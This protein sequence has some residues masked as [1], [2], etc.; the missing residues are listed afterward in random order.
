M[1]GYVSAAVIVSGLLGSFVVGA[2]LD[3]T[4][5]FIGTQRILALVGIASGLSVSD[6]NASD[7]TN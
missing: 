4:K 6:S 7:F 3:R 1:A 5:W 2:L